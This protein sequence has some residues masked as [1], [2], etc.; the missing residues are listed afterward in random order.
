MLT[1]LL[2]IIAG[3]FLS[4]LGAILPVWSPIPAD[5]TSLLGTMFGYLNSMSWFI[6]IND[7]YMALSIAFT[8]DLLMFSW[9]GF[10]WLRHNI[11]FLH[12]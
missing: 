4:I 6:P 8:V 3:G 12:K 1:D 2:L 5:F 7:L 9:V 11:P 10:Q